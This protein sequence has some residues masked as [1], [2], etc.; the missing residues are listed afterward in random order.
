MSTLQEDRAE[1]HPCDLR[2]SQIGELK[3]HD[4]PSPVRPEQQA[5]P[6]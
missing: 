5:E 2:V 6:Q 4:I 3:G 1:K